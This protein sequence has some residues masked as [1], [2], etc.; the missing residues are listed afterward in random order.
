[1]TRDQ[2][3]WTLTGLGVLISVVF[4]LWVI[5]LY[6]HFRVEKK[7]S[8]GIKN[9]PSMV[10]ECLSAHIADNGKGTDVSLQ[11]N[12]M[13]ISLFDALIRTAMLHDHYV[14]LA[15]TTLTKLTIHAVA[16]RVSN[17]SS[18][19]RRPTMATDR[20]AHPRVRTRGGSKCVRTLRMHLRKIATLGLLGVAYARSTVPRVSLPPNQSPSEATPERDM[21]LVYLAVLPLVILV[22][23]LAVVMVAH[24]D[25]ES[26]PKRR[27]TEDLS[28]A[29]DEPSAQPSTTQ[30]TGGVTDKE[31]QVCSTSTQSASL[32]AFTEM[33]PHTVHNPRP[34]PPHQTVYE[35]L[36]CWIDRRILQ[37][38][39]ANKSQEYNDCTSNEKLNFW[40]PHVYDRP[41]GNPEPS[42]NSGVR[43]NA[44]WLAQY[45]CP[46][47]FAVGTLIDRTREMLA[48][49]K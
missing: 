46:N 2:V 19:T 21:R 47:M 33:L 25:E 4:S 41:L 3:I 11:V 15:Q 10:S 31:P 18:R 14:Y 34:P 49:G 16:N 7:R 32:G 42:A 38:V 43:S 48:V 12:T 26:S 35:V 9:L 37:N 8:Q 39:W 44:R 29:N 27:R 17:K 5:A 6:Q 23:L 40:N 24:G 13:K 20:L 28:T 1:M 36:K 45:F 22:P 30:T